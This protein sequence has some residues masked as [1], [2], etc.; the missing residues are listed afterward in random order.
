MGEHLFKHNIVLIP[1]CGGNKILVKGIV[2]KDE[3]AVVLQP[4]LSTLYEIENNWK[5]RY[6]FCSNNYKEYYVRDH[7]QDMNRPLTKELIKP[8]VVTISKA[9]NH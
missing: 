8:I 2:R 5:I 6:Y 4:E 7:Y 9:L 3:S 1:S